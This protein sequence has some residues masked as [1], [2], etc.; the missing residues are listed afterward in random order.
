MSETTVTQWDGI[1]ST[2]CCVRDKL[3]QYRKGDS[4]ILKKGALFYAVFHCTLSQQ[5][6][7]VNTVSSAKI[8]YHLSRGFQTLTNAQNIYRFEGAGI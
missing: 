2:F 7:A 4:N 8:N 3:G 1:N 5:I 6:A